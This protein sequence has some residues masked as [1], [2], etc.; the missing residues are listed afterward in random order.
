MPESTWGSTTRADPA[1]LNM[2]AL[3]GAGHPYGRSYQTPMPVRLY[4]GDPAPVEAQD[5]MGLLRSRAAAEFAIVRWP[6]TPGRLDGAQ[7]CQFSRV[8]VS[9]SSERC[10]P[11]QLAWYAV[12]GVAAGAG[13]GAAASRFHRQPNARTGSGVTRHLGGHNQYILRFLRRS[14]PPDGRASDDRAV[15]I[16]QGKRL[17]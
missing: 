4:P 14:L 3:T 10:A 15:H 9:P 2:S 11:Y 12:T 5:S 8:V 16:A 17:L 13:A 7:V 6:D 1:S